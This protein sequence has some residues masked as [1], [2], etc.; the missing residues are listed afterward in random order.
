MLNVEIR[1]QI[2]LN[3]PPTL[4]PFAYEEG[5]L[6]GKPSSSE[7]HPYEKRI[8]SVN[9]SF[10]SFCGLRHVRL[11]EANSI[12]RVLKLFNQSLAPRE[13]CC[14][15]F[16]LGNKGLLA[17]PCLAS[18]TTPVSLSSATAPLPA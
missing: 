17:L 2:V 14:C 3:I 8:L 12:S 18:P 13:R 16:R 7:R 10:F 11:E 1:M 9:L 6:M 15:L 4:Y 5:V